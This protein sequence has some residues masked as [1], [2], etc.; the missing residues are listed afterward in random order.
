[1][2]KNLHQSSNPGDG[3]GR[4]EEKREGKIEA[5]SEGGY[6]TGPIYL[7]DR[8]CIFIVPPELRPFFESHLIPT[9]STVDNNG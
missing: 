6:C 7:P 2:C 8:Y 1:M 5:L 9:F 3:F 4:A